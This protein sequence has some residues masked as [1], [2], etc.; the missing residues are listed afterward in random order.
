MVFEALHF[1]FII[2]A[3]LRLRGLSRSDYDRL[4]D[5]HTSAKKCGGRGECAHSSRT[6]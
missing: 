4:T 1:V 5:D 3:S 2:T 6:A